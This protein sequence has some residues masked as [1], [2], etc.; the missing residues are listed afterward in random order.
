[1]SAPYTKKLFYIAN[2]R[3]PTEKAHGKQILCTC[4]ALRAQGADIT[5]VVPRRKNPLA[6]DPFSYYGIK[7]QFIMRRVWCLD[8]MT[9]PVFKKLTF[10][11]QVVS[12]G[13]RTIP[14]VWLRRNDSVIY[15]RDVPIGYL[16]SLVCKEVYFEA[17]SFPEHPNI[18]LRRV[19][20]ACRGVI[21][22]SGGV[23]EELVA[24][25]VDEA[26]IA[27]AHDGVD[28]SSI[29][30]S[31]SREQ[32]REALHL[33]PDATLV[34]YTG[35]LYDWKG[36]STLAHAAQSID[37]NIQ[38]WLI[39]GTDA[40]VSAFSREYKGTRNLHFTGHRPPQEIPLWLRAANIVV[41]PNSGKSRVSS[42]FTSPLKLFEYM[43]SER[44]IVCSDLP[45]LRE[46]VADDEVIFFEPDNAQECARAITRALSLDS[47][48]VGRRAQ[49]LLA[50]VQRYTWRARARIISTFIYG[51][52]SITHNT[53]I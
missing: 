22:I 48:E 8:L 45:S 50:K 1:M 4:D 42:K 6:G 39:G 7:K 47:A 40:D 41:L 9:L 10:L 21:A 19:L 12:F 24:Y 17:H 2:A 18:F 29:H 20:R 44:V 16:A 34:V 51:A 37:E 11:L 35:H 53:G 26:R 46:V 31:S 43:A 33:A 5:L 14:I 3:V 13:V 28:V 25:G 52:S 38:I 30:I 23:K 49:L 32:A 27:V 15:C 36:V